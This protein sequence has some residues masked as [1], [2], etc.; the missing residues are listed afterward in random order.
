MTGWQQNTPVPPPRRRPIEFRRV[1]IGFGIAMG[2]NL[3]ILV[4]MLFGLGTQDGVIFGGFLYLILQVLLVP[5][6][7]VTGIVQTIRQDGGIGVGLMIGWA[8]GG[9]V[10]FGGC[11][12]LLNAGGV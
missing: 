8:I 10:S 4:P 1:A 3:L 9:L 11:I 5:G 7:L 12:A 6:L 2:V